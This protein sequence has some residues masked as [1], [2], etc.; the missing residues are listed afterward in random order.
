MA[1]KNNTII[2]RLDA[3]QGEL[4][5]AASNAK[6]REDYH[7]SQ[8]KVAQDDAAVASKQQAAVAQALA[9]LTEAGVTV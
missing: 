2:A 9:I 3:K 4:A 8:I 5:T 6:D 7:R 1:R